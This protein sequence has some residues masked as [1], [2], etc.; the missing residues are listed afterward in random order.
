MNGMSCAAPLLGGTGVNYHEARSLISDFCAATANSIIENSTNETGILK[1]AS[2]NSDILLTISYTTTR[3]TYDT[4]CSLEPTASFTVSQST[5]EK[6]FYRLLDECDTAA[7]G[8][9]GKFGGTVTSG[10]GVYTLE[11]TPEEIIECGNNPYPRSVD[12]SWT[13]M[14]K[15]IANYCNTPLQLTPEYIYS[16]SFLIDTPKGQSLGNYLEGD[17][18]VKTVTQF[19]GQGQTDCGYSKPF[20]T[21]GDE[22]KRKLTSIIDQCGGKGGVLSENGK[23]GC[24]LWTIWG[25][26]AT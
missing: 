19:N 26:H 10:C 9:L 25:Q 16:D 4:S 7:S 2:G 13:A 3:Q 1:T 23:H 6:A 18:V 14:S 17:V 20:N 5:C 8:Y 21:N 24:V 12:M 11:T 15:G 22:C